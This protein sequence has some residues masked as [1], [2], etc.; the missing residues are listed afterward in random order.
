M[1]EKIPKMPF[2]EL[3]PITPGRA[4]FWIN[5]IILILS[6][7]WEPII[8]DSIFLFGVSIIGIVISLFLWYEEM[9]TYPK[10]QLM[11]APVNYWANF[12]NAIRGIVVVYI[13]SLVIWAIIRYILL[14]TF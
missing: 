10:T 2:G 3:K 1:T 4:L 9:V 6:L 12:N 5:G 7:F 14:L 13:C 8:F 11:Y